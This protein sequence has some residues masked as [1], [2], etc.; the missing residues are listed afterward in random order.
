MA[1]F[2]YTERGTSTKERWYSCAYCKSGQIPPEQHVGNVIVASSVVKSV[3]EWDMSFPTE[4][5]SL[6]NQYECGQMSL[7]GLFSSTVK[8][9]SMTQYGHLQGEVNAITKLDKHYVPRALW[10]F[11]H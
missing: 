4:V 5:Q 7:C 9:A 3:G 10:F 11:R 6:A 8:E 1:G 2:V